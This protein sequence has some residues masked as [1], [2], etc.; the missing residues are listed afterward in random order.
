[1]TPCLSLRLVLATVGSRGD[2]QPM[3]ALGQEL[4]QRG[5]QIRIAAPPDFADWV[6]SF[7]FDFA[8]LGLNMR[9]FLADH[10][11]VLTGNMRRAMPLLKRYF[12]D[13]LPRQMQ[14]LLA[15]CGD[16]D[17][18]V[19]AGLALT[20]PSVA[21]RLGIPVLGVLYSTCL[22]PSGLHPPP[23]LRWHGLPPWLNRALWWLHDRM[24]ADMVG[25][26]LNH[27]RIQAGLIAVDLR[28]HLE[29]GCDYAITADEALFP[30]DPVWPPNLRRANFLFLDDPEPLDPELDTWLQDGEPPIYIGFGSMGGTA[31]HRMEALLTQALLNSGRRV[32]IAA[33]WA[34]LGQQALP[35]G[36]RRIA[37]APHALLFPRLALVVHH[38]GSG[39]TA[40]A[41]RAGV[42]QVLLPLILDQY[43][44]AHRLYLAGLAPQPVS[45]ENISAEQISQSIKAAIAWPLP[46]RQTAALRLRQSDGVAQVGDQMEALWTASNSGVKV[47]TP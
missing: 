26:P 19:W 45:M 22:V 12:A 46:V 5:H 20:A 36:W 1:M 33:G 44:H 30:T 13:A 27:G 10:P 14:E 28:D 2:V 38:G 16:A 42:P 47:A 15:I 37:A 29:H 24:A 40:Q 6:Q 7:G 43:H 23:T 32:L 34:G 41:L 8:P 18:L 9:Q 11:D 31:T 4:R 21:E 3:L 35:P 17:V 39:T 25:R